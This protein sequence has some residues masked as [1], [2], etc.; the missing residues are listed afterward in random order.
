MARMLAASMNRAAATLD[1]IRRNVAVG[2]FVEATTQ[3]TLV[4]G[5][6]LSAGLLIARLGGRHLSPATW[7]WS[8]LALPIAYGTV[9][10]YRRTP[11]TA[12]VSAWLDRRGGLGGLLVTSR[13]VDAAAWDSELSTRLAAAKIPS[14]TVVRRADFGRAVIGAAAMAV[15]LFL[16]APVA[17]GP[18]SSHPAISA[19]VED[20]RAEL[21]ELEQ[22][23]AVDAAATEE[24]R[25]KLE[26]LQE[27]LTE[28]DPV[29][30]SEVDAIERRMTEAKALREDSLETAQAA[31]AAAA[32]PGGETDAAAR[33]EQLAKALEKAAAAGLLDSLPQAL[34][35]RLGSGAPGGAPFDPESLKLSA[36]DLAKL[37]ADLAEVLAGDLEDLAA[38]GLADPAAAKRLAGKG[39]D[40]WEDAEDHVHGPECEGGT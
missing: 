2:L 17:A 27:K 34:K 1:K 33:A 22:H 9:V 39:A 5:T 18:R 8:V 16:P 37:A 29:A 15:V 36:E 40:E 3:A 24:I 21:Q 28:G 11:G 6:V 14:P 4:V 23:K 30:W 10:A 38:A 19:A 25:E 32:A 13:E 26:K 35:D 7:W 20:L 31:L 12:A